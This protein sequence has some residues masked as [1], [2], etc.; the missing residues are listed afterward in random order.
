MFGTYLPFVI[1]G[2]TVGSVYGLAALG[3]VLTYQTTGVFNFAYGAVAAVSVFVF[4]W[5]HTE[6]HWPWPLAAAACIG[7]LATVEGLALERMTRAMSKVAEVYKIVATVGL[8]LIVIGVGNLWYGQ[9]TAL[10]PSFLPTSTFEVGGINVGWDQ[11]TVVVIAFISAAGLFMFFRFARSGA[12]MRAA[13]DSRQLLAMTG[14]NPVRVQR[15]AWIIGTAF[16]SMAGLLLAPELGLNGV[17]LTALVAQAFGAAAIGRL[18]NLPLTYFGGLVIGVL[19]ALSTKYSDITWFAGVPAGLPFA[20]LFLVLILTPRTKLVSQRSQSIGLVH[21]SWN[22]PIRIRAGAWVLVVAAF[23]LAPAYAGPKLSYYSITV[24]FVLMFSALGLVVRTSGQLLLCPL[25]FAAIGAAAM[26]HLSVGA[27]VPWGLAVLLAGMIAVPIGAIVAIPAVR[28]SGIYLALATYGFGLLVESVA[29]PQSFMFGQT[30][31]GVPVHRPALRIAGWDLASD[32][33]FFYLLLLLVTMLSGVVLALQSG[34]LGRLLRGLSD[35]P[36]SLEVSGATTTVTKVIVLCIAAFLLAIGGALVG[37][38]YSYES[39]SD[40]S[41][42]ASLQMVV[43]V[44]IVLIGDP[45]VAIVAAVSMQLIPSYF[46]TSFANYLLIIFGVFAATFAMTLDRVPTVPSSV[47]R[48]LDRLGGRTEKTLV[49]TPPAVAVSH[50]RTSRGKATQAIEPY[51]VVRD[52]SVRFG[53]LRAVD[54]FSMTAEL[55][56]I[57]GLI[58]PNGAGKSTTLDACSGFVHP[59]SGAITV[60]GQHIHHAGVAARA[61]MGLGRTFQRDDLFDSLTVLENLVVAYEAGQ[62][63]RNPLAHVI[64]RRGNRDAARA[65]AADAMEVTG[66]TPLATVRASALST[67]HKRLVEVARALAGSFNML[68][69]DE[70]SSGLHGTEVDRFGDMLLQVV[71]ERGL[72]IVLVEHDIGLVRRVCDKVY[73]MDFGRLAFVGTTDEMLRSDAVRSA[74]LGADTEVELGTRRGSPAQAPGESS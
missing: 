45:W 1:I 11:A 19:A 26:S 5:L 9:N 60:N 69:L 47:Q 66:V 51:L 32:T 58:G 49:R 50:I 35:S 74:Y 55:G 65:V 63:G 23:A 16:A 2:L 13:V 41:S 7:G 38:L 46:G 21:R 70:P 39:G 54:Q 67:G 52:L 37:A 10:F 30:P 20:V 73:M 33:G 34:K 6:H 64:G 14:E 22:A 29:Y 8:I 18:S 71:E 27:G 40:M 68:L 44:S 25:T 12:A 36:R 62:S 53:G 56:H 15:I 31:A 43:L 48:M 4:Y 72:G 59:A 3:L 17:L 57:T 61:R 24:I 42:F 28:L